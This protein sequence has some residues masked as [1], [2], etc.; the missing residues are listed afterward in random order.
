MVA[1]IAEALAGS[2]IAFT[3]G[4]KLLELGQ[5]LR[6]LA[7]P[8]AAPLLPVGFIGELRPYQK[9]GLGWLTALAQT[10]FGG[11]LADDMGLGKTVQALAFLAGQKQAN[12]GDLP[13]LIIVP[14][15][16]VGTWQSEAA[17]FTPDLR[18]LFLH[19]P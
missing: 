17:R 13:N 18:V 1:D 15:S 10:G 7:K 3:G 11:V 16:L 19:G 6:A 9:I 8:D 4:E 14:T 2:N 12:A 5:R